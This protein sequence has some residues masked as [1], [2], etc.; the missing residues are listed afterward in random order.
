MPDS[1]APSPAPSAAPQGPGTTRHISPLVVWLLV[2]VVAAVAFGAV[3]V[4]SGG[5]GGVMKMLGLSPATV[6]TPAPP[7]AP[8]A[9][10]VPT[11][12]VSAVA[13]SPGLPAEAQNRMYTEQLQSQATIKELLGKKVSI[14]R[15]GTPSASGPMA[16]VP[17]TVVYKS[18][19]TYSGTMALRK[20]G[21]MWYFFS[22]TAASATGGGNTPAP[23]AFDSAVVAAITGQQATP[24]NQ[25]VLVDGVLGGGFKT[26]KVTGVTRGAGTATV[27]VLL[28]GGTAKPTAG[29]LVCISKTDGTTPYWFIARFD[30]R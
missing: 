29:R 2:L 4:A 19:S 28:S 12:P 1:A 8:A 24:A 10:V 6:S 5:I 16:R 20:Y 7:S 25:H 21:R 9:S 30:A 13:S 3:V 26:I 22:M 11:A 18:G 27:N 15:M 14:I 17:V 23:T